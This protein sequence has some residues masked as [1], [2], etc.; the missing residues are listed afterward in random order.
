M[1]S[2]RSVNEYPRILTTYLEN[3]QRTRLML[4]E[5]THVG[6]VMVRNATSSLTTLRR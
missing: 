2:S 4:T 3:D 1:K 6:M 5:G